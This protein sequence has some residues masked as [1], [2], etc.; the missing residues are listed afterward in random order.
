MKRRIDP[1][2]LAYPDNPVMHV[3]DT[4]RLRAAAFWHLLPSGEVRVP[5]GAVGKVEA[6]HSAD[7]GK[8]LAIRFEGYTHPVT[9]VFPKGLHVAGQS[10]YS[11][12][13]ELISRGGKHVT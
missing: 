6:W 3:G 11:D 7:W 4:I 5:T 1:S 8:G 10:R 13:Y 2:V 9:Q 12:T